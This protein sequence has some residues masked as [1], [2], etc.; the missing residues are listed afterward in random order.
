MKRILEMDILVEF[1]SFFLLLN[2]SLIE[3][4]R[5]ERFDTEV[6]LNEI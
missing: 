4:I 6:R 2:T 1:S 5:V 3:L